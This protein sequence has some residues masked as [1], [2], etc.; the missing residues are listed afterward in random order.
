MKA[1]QAKEPN[2]LTESVLQ[3]SKQPYEE[4]SVS[5]KDPEGNHVASSLQFYQS[6]WTPKRKERK[7]LLQPGKAFMD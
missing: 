5:V 3:K 2:E 6:G 4:C 1:K 7:K